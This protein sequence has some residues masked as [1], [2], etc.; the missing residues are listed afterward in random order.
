MISKELLKEVFDVN[1]IFVFP[2]VYETNH[3]IESQFISFDS[4]DGY[5][6]INIYELAHKCKEWS[7]KE[8]YY[9]FSTLLVDSE[10]G[11]AIINF[12]SDDEVEIITSSEPESVFTACQWI[13]DKKETK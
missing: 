9:V 8:G 13:L 1:V 4:S 7:K 11:V 6:K 12:G 3:G 10:E 2:I 5:K